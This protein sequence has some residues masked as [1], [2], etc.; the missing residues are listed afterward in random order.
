MCALRVILDRP[1]DPAEPL[2]HVPDDVI[3][4]CNGDSGG[5]LVAPSGAGGD[6]TV[7]AQWKLVGVVS[8]GSANCDHARLPGVYARVSSP[9]IRAFLDDPSPVFMPFPTSAPVLSGSPAVGETVSCASG[10]WA[11]DPGA[12]DF[13]ILSGSAIVADTSSYVVR[14]TD[15]GR[16][17]RCRVSATNAGGTGSADSNTLAVPPPPKPEPT[18][19]PTAERVEPPP[20]APQP[21]PPVAEPPPPLPPVIS[22]DLLAPRAAIDG[23]VCRLR[24]CTILVFADDRGHSGVRTVLVKLTRRKG[25][26]TIRYRVRVTRLTGGDFRLR[27]PR[28]PAG[29]YTLAVRAVDRAGNRQRTAT[30]ARFTIRRPG[31]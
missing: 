19:A 3:D 1:N 2:R 30:T 14:A 6:L 15:R 7:S 25:G 20:A 11:H 12:Y 17:L 26:R 13:V 18:P 21:A 9:V 24:A 27:T 28:L 10:A 22:A 31:R 29:R 5:P 8:F 4:S 16:A 23:R